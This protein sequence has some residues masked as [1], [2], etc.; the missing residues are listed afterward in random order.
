MST[1]NHQP[2]SVLRRKMLILIE[3]A[4]FFQQKRSFSEFGTDGIENLVECHKL[5]EKCYC[6][7]YT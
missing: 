1:I 2:A 6:V 5:K 3:T 7:L 4:F